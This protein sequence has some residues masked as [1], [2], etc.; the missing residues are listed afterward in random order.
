MSIYCETP[1]PKAQRI[2]IGK[3][4]NPAKRRGQYPATWDS[5]AQGGR[6]MRRNPREVSL[7]FAS[8]DELTNITALRL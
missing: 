5:M 2:G 3:L 7:S 4:N 1:I 8:R 6:G